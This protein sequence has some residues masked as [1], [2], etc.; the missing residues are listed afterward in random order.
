[1]IQFRCW[2]CNKRYAVPE[3][4]VGE[5]LT[6]T[7]KYALR[8]P[9][10]SGGNSRSKTAVDWLVEAVVYGG[11]GG[12]LGLGLAILILSKVRF[13][14]FLEPA[15]LFIAVLTLTGILAGALGGERGVNWI[16]RM[17]RDREES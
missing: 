16:G 13:L 15:W 12:L 14:L 10:R 1:M 17:I 11:G 7:C 9:Q 3:K 2:Y 5:R 4:R 6:C 8:V